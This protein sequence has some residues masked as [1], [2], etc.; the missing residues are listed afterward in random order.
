MPTIIIPIIYLKTQYKY[1]LIN[2]EKNIVK[3]KEK[4][5]DSYMTR[6]DKKFKYTKI[7]YYF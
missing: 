5:I 3:Q 7:L 4:M 1:R 2:H 6:L